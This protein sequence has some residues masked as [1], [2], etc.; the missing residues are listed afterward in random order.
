MRRWAIS[1]FLGNEGGAVTVDWIVLTASI[2]GLGFVVM[3]GFNDA[4]QG[5]ALEIVDELSDTNGDSAVVSSV[6]SGADF[7]AGFVPISPR[8]GAGSSDPS[9]AAAWAQAAYDRMSSKS[10]DALIKGY[11]RSYAAA[12]TGQSSARADS[13][14]VSQQVMSERGLGIPAGNQS[15]AAI[16]M[17]Y[18]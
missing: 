17:L 18:E 15:A 13:V 5:A 2:V 3:T 14:A 16:R 9:K 11:N 12:A 4:V 6:L 7:L 1:R 10:D 8:H